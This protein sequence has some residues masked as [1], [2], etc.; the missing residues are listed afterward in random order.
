VLG[1]LQVVGDPLAP[2]IGRQQ[3]LPRL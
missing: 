1:R 3:K 2:V